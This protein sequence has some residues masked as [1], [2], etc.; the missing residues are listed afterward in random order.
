MHYRRH[1]ESMS[2]DPIKQLRDT[3]AV[4]NHMITKYPQAQPYRS[5]LSDG[6]VALR[7]KLEERMR[8]S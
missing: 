5:E 4:W 7:K 3:I 8:L 6:L 2:A 1:P